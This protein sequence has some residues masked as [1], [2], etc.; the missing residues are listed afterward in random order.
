MFTYRDFL[1]CPICGAKLERKDN[2]FIC[3]SAD[4]GKRHCFDISSSGYSDLSYRKGGA[5]DPK[6]AVRDRTLFLDKGYYEP[7]ARE[8]L[9]LCTM[10]TDSS[11]FI[12]DAGCGEGYYSEFIASRCIESFLFGADLSKHAADK[13]SKRRNMRGGDNSFYSVASIFSLPLARGCAD[14]VVSMFAPIAESEFLRVLKDGGVL[15]IGV[16]GRNHLYEL[17]SEI[18]D[19]VRLND[20]RADMPANMEFAEKTNVS[21]IASIDNSEDI[22][23]LFG[24]TPYK[25]RTS[26]KAY[27]RLMRLNSLNVR[28]DVDFYV[29]RK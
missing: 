8:L 22:Q 2:S 29:F 24:M 27:E 4:G 19:D 12:V 3:E 15:I 28:I 20:D 21:Y 25:F 10:H 23:R 5:G 6:D 13:A 1:R 18:Y 7:L 26:V 14:A 9:K 17:K 16:A 11:S